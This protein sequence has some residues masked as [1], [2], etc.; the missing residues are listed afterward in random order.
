MKRILFILFSSISLLL[1]SCQKEIDWGTGGGGGGT[2]SGNLLVKT[3]A[4][5]G[6]DSTVTVYTYNSNQKL[7]NEKITGRS[8]GFDVSNEF[9]YYRNASGII[10]HYV[11]IN[12][13]FVI[14]GIDSVTTY[15]NYDAASSRY[16]SYVSELALMGFAVR[17]SIAIIYNAGGKVTQTEQYQK[18]PLLGGDYEISLRVKYT[19][20]AGGN[21]LQQD[22]YSVDPATMT[23]DLISNIKYTFDVKPA[24]ISF[25]NEA[26]TIGKPDLI[27]VNNA[28]KVEFIDLGTPSNGFIQSNV[29]TYNT[30]NKPGSAVSTRTPGPV[31]NNVTYYYQ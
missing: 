26:Y 28:T 22:F 10:T 14:V 21:M 1:I 16:T 8:Q 6:T 19:Y 7:L 17:D 9:R 3:V 2:S 31:V 23:E 4:K 20:D 11:Q 18:I 27:S 29:Y 24:A 15:V 30:N 12:P 25:D 5:E 13:N